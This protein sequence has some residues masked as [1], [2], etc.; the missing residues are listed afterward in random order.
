MTVLVRAPETYVPER[1]YVVALVLG[2]WLG[3]DHELSFEAR[4]DVA[5]QVAGDKLEQT[6][7]IADRLFATPTADWL[8]ERSL[9]A[10]PV[11]QF[12]DQAEA[13]APGAASPASAGPLPVLFGSPD[14]TGRWWRR[15]ER[16]IE[17]GIDI[18]GSVFFMLTRYEELVLAQRDGHGRFPARA[19]LAGAEGIPGSSDR[20]RLRR[21]AVAGAPGALACASSAGRRPSDCA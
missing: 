1:R 16:E 18:F 6:V 15:G 5:V 7:L 13:L 20:G 2:E 10:R 9:P 8:T 12:G 17:L 4:S 21:P 14:D 3:L 19:S 11:Q